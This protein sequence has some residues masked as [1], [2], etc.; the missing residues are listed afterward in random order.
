MAAILMFSS[1]VVSENITEMLPA[2]VHLAAM[3]MNWR[4]LLE[5]WRT[6]RAS[7]IW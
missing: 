6:S 2:G 3:G 7:M 5:L 4:A 1:F